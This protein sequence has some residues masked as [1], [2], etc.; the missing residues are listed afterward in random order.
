MI[1]HGKSS[2][3]ATQEDKIGSAQVANEKPLI[4]K[5]KKKLP[6][7]YAISAYAIKWENYPIILNMNGKLSKYIE[8]QN[9]WAGI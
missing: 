2:R 5:E 9:L 4:V 3:F 6:V 7:V 1:Q 8:N